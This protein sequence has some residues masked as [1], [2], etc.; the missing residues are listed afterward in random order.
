MQRWFFLAILKGCL[1]NRFLPNS[2]KI[3]MVVILTIA[4]G[5]GVWEILTNKDSARRSA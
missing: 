1:Q 5:P 4:K 3:F 2:F